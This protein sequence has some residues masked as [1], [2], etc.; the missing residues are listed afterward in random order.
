MAS[1]T[2][3]YGFPY[4]QDIDIVDVAGDIQ[5]LAES[6][7]SKLSEAIADTVGAMVTSNTENGITVTYD[8]SDNTLDFD[9]ADFSVTFLGDVTGSTTITNLANA[10][11]T[12]A[13]V[14]D[15]H[16]HT[17]ATITDF[18]E[19][20][21]DVVGGM[22]TSNTENGIT[23]TYDDGTNTLNFDVGDFDIILSGDLSGSA[24]VTNLGNINLSASVLD[25]SHFHIAADVTDFNSTVQSIIDSFSTINVPS[26]TDPVATLYNDALVIT[27]NNGILING[28]GSN[29]IDISTNATPLNNASAIVSRD[30]NRSFDITAIDFDT[31]ASATAAVGRLHWDDGEGSLTFTLK[32]GNIDLPIGQKEVVLCYN[33]SGSPMTKG[34]VVYISGAQGQKPSISLSNAATEAGSTKTFGVVSESIANGADGFVTTFGIVRGINTIAYAEGDLLWLSAS[35]GQFTNVMPEAPNHG[36][37]IGYVIR[38]HASS[39]E[40]FVRVDNGPELGEIHDVALTSVTDG[41]TLIYSSSASAWVNTSFNERAQDTIATMINNGTHTNISISYND[42]A[43]SLSFTGS[44]TV[45]DEQVQDAIAPLFTHSNHTNITATYDD[46][47]NEII[48]V[49]SASGGGS[50]VA[51]NVALSQSWWLGV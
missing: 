46:A 3:N 5:E 38:S 47:N 4:P 37:F 31:S 45:T 48:L 7:D 33:G 43:N 34:Q 41:D 6:I 21:A 18:G 8:D 28:T 42:A 49:G 19:A 23:V 20:V 30:S 24:T 51:T 14:D 25:S 40:I 50:G 26:G 1:A 12:L 2:I 15:S 39:G 22:V 29:T 27:E 44:A 17:S 10:S 13:V 11:A 16:N 9:V 32:N 35:A 36:V